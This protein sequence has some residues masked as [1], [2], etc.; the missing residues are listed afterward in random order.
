MAQ[1]NTL[2]GQQAHYAFFKIVESPATPGVRNRPRST[3]P[4]GFANPAI[5][6]ARRPSVCAGNDVTSDAGGS[7]LQTTTLREGSLVSA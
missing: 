4:I 5:I 7:C 2:D 6:N 1:T 3:S